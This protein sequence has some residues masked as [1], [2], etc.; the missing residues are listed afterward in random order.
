[1]G[2]AESMEHTKLDFGSDPAFAAWGLDLSPRSLV[3]Y[4]I[5]STEPGHVLNSNPFLFKVVTSSGQTWHIAAVWASRR[6][7]VKA[8]VWLWL[9]DAF[10]VGMA[11]HRSKHNDTNLFGMAR[12]P[13]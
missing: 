2:G 11:N 12:P 5:S 9:L 13:C 3:G 8:R 10:G 7:R 1:M 4:Y 6:F